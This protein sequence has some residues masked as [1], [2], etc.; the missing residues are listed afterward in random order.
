MPTKQPEHAG[1][2]NQQ[3]RASVRNKDDVDEILRDATADLETVRGKKLFITGGTGFFGNDNVT[4]TYSGVS[5]AAGVSIS[6]GQLA[7]VYTVSASHAGASFTTP[8]SITDNSVVS[9]KADVFVDPNSHL[10]LLLFNS[11]PAQTASL[12]IHP[13]DVKI[14]ISGTPN[15]VADVFDHNGALS[16]LIRFTG[17]GKVVD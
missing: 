4:V 8:I 16:S 2:A 14:K 1:Q 13:T 9:F 17:F 5:Q 11:N 15:G 3:N 6:T 7:D 10:N 12:T